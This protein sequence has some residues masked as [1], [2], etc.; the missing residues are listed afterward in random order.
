RDGA[1]HARREPRGPVS[2]A[3]KNPTLDPAAAAAASSASAA[4]DE[5][6]ERTHWEELARL[7]PYARNHRVLLTVTLILSLLLAVIDVPVPFMLKHII[8]AVLKHHSPLVFLG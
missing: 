5:G 6:R 1:G 8:D 7:V 2:E 4:L 3:F